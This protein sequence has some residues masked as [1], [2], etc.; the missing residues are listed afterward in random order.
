LFNPSIGGE[1]VFSG[2]KSPGRRKTMRRD[3]KLFKV[4][5]GERIPYE[6]KNALLNY[7]GGQIKEGRTVVQALS[8]KELAALWVARKKQKQKKEVK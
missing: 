6:T 2:A 3:K 8:K 4:S 5:I 7:F 1:I